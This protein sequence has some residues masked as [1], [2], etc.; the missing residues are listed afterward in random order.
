MRSLRLKN[1][2][3]A[4]ARDPR[5][6]LAASQYSRRTKRPTG[7]VLTSRAAAQR[8]AVAAETAAIQRG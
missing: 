7:A 1:L 4:V 3:R 6:L 2:L 5:R 8:L